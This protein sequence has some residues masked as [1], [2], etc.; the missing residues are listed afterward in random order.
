MQDF[1]CAGAEGEAGCG[2]E[3]NEEQGVRLGPGL[4]SGGG[5]EE[6]G[7]VEPSEGQGALLMRV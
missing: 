4:G 7:P 3:S 1:E 6:R 2:V 5:F